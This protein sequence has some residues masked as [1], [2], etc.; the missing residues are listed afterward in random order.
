MYGWMGWVAVLNPSTQTMERVYPLI[1]IAYGRA[2]A[3]VKK[4][5]VNY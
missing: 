5:L 3:S 4:R 1:K 2:S